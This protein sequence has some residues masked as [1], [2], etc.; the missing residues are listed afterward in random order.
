[1]PI[2][3]HGKYYVWKLKAAGDGKTYTVHKTIVKV[4]KMAQ[5]NI[6]ISEGLNKDDIIAAAG[7]N[8]L[9]EGQRVYLLDTR[10][11]SK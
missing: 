4:G 6:K 9:Q 10:M 2:D 5:G 11:E 1:V 8:S 7:V 3:E